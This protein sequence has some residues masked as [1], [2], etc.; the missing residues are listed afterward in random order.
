M[1]FLFTISEQVPKIQNDLT[2]NVMLVFWSQVLSIL[3]SVVLASQIYLSSR[4]ETIPESIR[5]H[6]KVLLKSLN[7]NT[8]QQSMVQRSPY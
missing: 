7:T 3:S 2:W 5:L 4:F 6:L 1:F 8:V